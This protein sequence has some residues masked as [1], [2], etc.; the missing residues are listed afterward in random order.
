MDV[1]FFSLS[2]LLALVCLK[3]F[4]LVPKALRLILVPNLQTTS[5]YATSF[6]TTLFFLSLDN[7]QKAN[8]TNYYHD[9][10]F[11]EQKQLALRDNVVSDIWLS[12]FVKTV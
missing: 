3:K 2:N 4:L 9:K 10:N 5:F 6:W 12:V 8:N 7:F 1:T 11:L